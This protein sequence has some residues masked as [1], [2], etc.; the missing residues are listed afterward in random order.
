MPPLLASRLCV[1]FR[2][3]GGPLYEERM[4]Q[5]LQALRGEEPGPP[6]VNSESLVPP[7]GTG[8][9]VAGPLFRRLV[10]GDGKATLHVG[11]ATVMGEA[12]GLD[13]GGEERL[14]R[15]REAYR[16]R[17]VTER[18][19]GEPASAGDVPLV[20]WQREAGEALGRA[21]V[22][23]PVADAL[24]ADLR[25]AESR[26]VTLELGLEIADDKLLDHPWESLCLPSTPEARPEGALAL[27]PRVHLYRAVPGDGPV[28]A[29]S[30]PGPLRV[31]AWIPTVS[32]PLTSPPPSVGN[33][34]Q[35]PARIQQGSLGL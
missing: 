11:D 35:P 5:L 17:G 12:P 10:I 8:Y 15:L 23:A 34:S 25:T 13:H 6:I 27:H 1:D 26:G 7:P 18:C 32:D 20:R 30:I 22:P 4:R 19:E 9:V 2:G 31:L 24:R 16:R 3:V 21:F 29:W 28:V 14:W 33:V